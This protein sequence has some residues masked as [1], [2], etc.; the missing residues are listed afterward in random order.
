MNKQLSWRYNTHC[1]FCKKSWGEVLK[2][3]RK[4]GK[5]VLCPKGKMFHRWVFNKNEKGL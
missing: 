4:A 5:R 1:D 2:E 3:R